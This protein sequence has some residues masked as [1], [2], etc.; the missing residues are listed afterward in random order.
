MEFDAERQRVERGIWRLLRAARGDDR[1]WRRAAGERAAELGGFARGLARAADEEVGA[2]AAEETLRL[3]DTGAGRALAEEVRR[4]AS[5]IETYHRR[6]AAELAAAA[7]VRLPDPERAVRRLEE[8]LVARL[9]G[10]ALARGSTGPVRRAAPAVRRPP[11][12]QARVPKFLLSR[13]YRQGNLRRFDDRTEVTFHNPLAF[14]IVQGGDPLVVDGRAFPK[15]RTVLDNGE[16]RVTGDQLS[17]ASYLK[18]TKGGAITVTLEGLVLAPGPHRLLA[19]LEMRKMGWVELDV[20]D[21]I[22]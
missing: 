12:K 8:A 10:A 21:T 7:E 22:A 20:K 1:A 13:F 18:F 15:E 14:C 5:A 11:R 4:V 19:A 2:A 17:G 6:V 16:K 9:G 3:A